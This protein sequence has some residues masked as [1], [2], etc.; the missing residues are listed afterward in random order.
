MRILGWLSSV[1]HHEKQTDT[2]RRRHGNTGM[3]FLELAEFQDWLKNETKN[4]LWCK[5]DPGVGKTI[6]S[7]VPTP[8]A[9]CPLIANSKSSL[10]I[11]HIIKT[12]K[13]A[14]VAFF[15]FDFSAEDEQTP[16][17]ILSSLLKQL[18]L[19]LRGLPAPVKQ[20]FD[21]SIMKAQIP[22]V[23]ELQELLLAMRKEF[24]AVYLVIDALDECKVGNC[25]S[26]ILEALQ[27]FQASMKLLVTSRPHLDDLNDSLGHASQVRLRAVESDI[28][29]YVLN[30]LE[31][32]KAKKILGKDEKLKE[33]IVTSIAEG[34]HGM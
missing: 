8:L 23:N 16:D 26:D 19:Q 11:D 4:I 2:L 29:D 3:W 31:T 28:R 22:Q 32:R 20:L 6:L 27:A 18:L 14:G 15:Y 25:R 24:N 1:A 12:R 34:A 33:E 13:D 21:R 5:G 7:Y 9:I 30:K 17:Q 10:A